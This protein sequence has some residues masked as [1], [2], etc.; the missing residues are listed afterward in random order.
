MTN[1]HPTF[2]P[3]FLP[4]LFQDFH[5]EVGIVVAPPGVV[6]VYAVAGPL[7]IAV[8]IAVA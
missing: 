2:Y 6:A 7:G 8:A 3:A 4:P 5:V 1:Y